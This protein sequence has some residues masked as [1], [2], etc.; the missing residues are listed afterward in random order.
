MYTLDDQAILSQLQVFPN[1][2]ADVLFIDSPV[3]GQL[4]IYSMLGKEA[5]NIK[6]SKGKNTVK[7]A[8][9][10]PGVYFGKVAWHGGKRVHKL[11]RTE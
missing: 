4:T 6:L 11:I 5:L 8:H 3:E 2:V 7:V 1:P 10:L 9:I